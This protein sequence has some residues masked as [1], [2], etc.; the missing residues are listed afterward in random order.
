MKDFFGLNNEM[1]SNL[2]EVIEREN[3][4]FTGDNWQ[5]LKD[6]SSNTILIKEGKQLLHFESFRWNNNY[7]SG[8]VELHKDNEYIYSSR[9]LIDRETNAV[10]LDLY[11]NVLLLWNAGRA[12]DALKQIEYNYNMK[13]SFDESMDQLQDVASSI[14]FN[15]RELSNFGFKV[16]T[17]EKFIDMLSACTINREDIESILELVRNEEKGLSELGIDIEEIEFIDNEEL[18]L[19]GLNYSERV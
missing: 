15:I 6:N 5:M 3:I 1:I 10:D 13:Y 4:G 8:R 16:D 17:I 7:I 12:Y 18:S 14:L 11:D 9:V 19:R 2:K